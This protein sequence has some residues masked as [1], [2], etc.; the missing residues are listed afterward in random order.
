MSEFIVQKITDRHPDPTKRI[1]C[2]TVKT[3]LERD[4]QTYSVSEINFARNIDFIVLGMRQ[5]MFNNNRYQFI[6]SLQ[7][8][9][10]RPLDDVFALVRDSEN[11]QLFHIEYKNGMT[12]SY[13]TND[14]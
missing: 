1:L 13:L 4:P 12:R 11:I 3:L 8:C 14:R 6:N 7:I 10:L 9:T 2:L 5:I